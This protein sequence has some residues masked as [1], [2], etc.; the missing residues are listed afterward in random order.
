MWRLRRDP[1][2]RR[3]WDALVLC[4]EPSG[5]IHVLSPLAEAVLDLLKKGPAL[6]EDLIRGASQLADLEGASS[7]DMTAAFADLLAAMDES[8]LIEKDLC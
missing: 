1:Q 7:E 6:T 8:G 4:H 3:R 2:E 5:D